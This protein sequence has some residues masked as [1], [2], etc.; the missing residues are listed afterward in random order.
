M[1]WSLGIRPFP[2]GFA[3]RTEDLS[4]DI[5]CRMDHAWSRKVLYE[6]LTLCRENTCST[7]CSKTSISGNFPHVRMMWQT[8]FK[9]ALLAFT[10]IVFFSTE[11]LVSFFNLLSKW[12]KRFAPSRRRC[13]ISGVLSHTNDSPLKSCWTCWGSPS[14]SG[15][16]KLAIIWPTPGLQTQSRLW[17]TL[18]GQDVRWCEQMGK[19]GDWGIKSFIASTWAYIVW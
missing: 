7:W 8:G 14:L 4:V 11:K 10:L 16:G 1:F 2:P 19:P 18:A 17:A 6:I 3:G 13:L 15:S 12:T 5:K 9:T